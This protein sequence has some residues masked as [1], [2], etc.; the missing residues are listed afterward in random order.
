MRAAKSPYLGSISAIILIGCLLH[1]LYGWSGE[2]RLIGYIAPVNESV[3]EH[4]KMSFWAVVLFAMI[5]YPVRR[6]KVHNFFP[7][8]ALSVTILIGTI[9]LV[10]YVYHALIGHGLV[11]LDILSFVVGV[12]FGRYA[13]FRFFSMPVWPTAIQQLC[14]LFLLAVALLFAL[15]T[16]APPD[17]EIFRDKSDTYRIHAPV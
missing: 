4:L 17:L 2:F 13:A 8:V 9:L 6:N 5:E 1:F 14:F 3:W 16:Y 7:A 10:F 11:W 12:I 15:T